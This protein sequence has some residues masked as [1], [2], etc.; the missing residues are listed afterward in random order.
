VIYIETAKH[1]TS[2]E[3]KIAFVQSFDRALLHKQAAPFI[4][5]PASEP[6]QIW[7]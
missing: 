4:L 1:F 3:Y 6:K 5:T 7:A 2:N